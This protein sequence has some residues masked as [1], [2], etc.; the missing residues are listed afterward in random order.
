M[1][2]LTQRDEKGNWN[3]AGVPWSGLGEGA[4]ITRDIWE[5]LYGALF[6][7]K[8]YE[9]TGLSPDEAESLKEFEGSNTQKYLMELA[10]HK[11]IPVEEQQPPERGNYLCT[12]ECLG[13]SY[14]IVGHYN[15]PG[16]TDDYCGQRVVAWQP[17]PEEYRPEKKG[18]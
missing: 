2:R 1:K 3:L 17:L 6:K 10:K 13:H 11:W 12:V 15:N 14:V 16:W 9:D 8:D 5:K 4:V 7:L 18:R